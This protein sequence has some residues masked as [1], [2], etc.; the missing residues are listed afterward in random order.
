M[1]RR[2]AFFLRRSHSREIA[3]IQNALAKEGRIEGDHVVVP[4]DFFTRLNQQLNADKPR[5][6]VLDMLVEKDT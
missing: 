2:P 3:M 6:S 1:R 4:E 5:P